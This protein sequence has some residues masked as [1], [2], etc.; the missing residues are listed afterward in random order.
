MLQ[1]SIPLVPASVSMFMLTYVDRLMVQKYLGLHELGVYGI[2]VRVASIVSLVVIATQNSLHPLIFNRFNASESPREIATIFRVYIGALLMFC[3]G[4]SLFAQELLLV[5]TAPQYFAAAGLVVF[6]APSL[7]LAQMYIF[8]PGMHLYKR[9][10]TI[11]LISCASAAVKVAG[12]V[13][14]IPVLGVTGAAIASLFSYLAFFS[15]YALFSQRLYTIPYE[16]KRIVTASSAILGLGWLVPMYSTEL[17][18]PKLAAFA[19]GMMIVLATRLVRL[20]EIRQ[21]AAWTRLQI[22]PSIS[23][24]P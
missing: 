20:S 12:N 24:I 16:W 8:T 19:F 1:Y 4:V 7:A 11:M 21:W 6:L 9:T 14:L 2:A 3:L 13:A 18:T 17:I 22:N 10:G 5:F 23:R 15:L